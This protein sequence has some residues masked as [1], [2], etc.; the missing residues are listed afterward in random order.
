MLPGKWRVAFE[1]RFH[2]GLQVPAPPAA[3]LAAAP[4][5]E[6]RHPTTPNVMTPVNQHN[7]VILSLS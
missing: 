2:C 1:L 6:A 4:F 5:A 3:D 7:I